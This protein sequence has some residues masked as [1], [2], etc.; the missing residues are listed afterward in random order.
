[1]GTISSSEGLYNTAHKNYA[2]YTVQLVYLGG[3]QGT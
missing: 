1:M 3:L 2:D